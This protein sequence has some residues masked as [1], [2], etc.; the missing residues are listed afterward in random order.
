SLKSLRVKRK[1]RRRLPAKI[2]E[3]R[4]D[5]RHWGFLRQRSATF[6]ANAKAGARVPVSKELS[7]A[8]IRLCVLSLGHY[9]CN[10]CQSHTVHP[11][12]QCAGEPTHSAFA[13]CLALCAELA[14]DHWWAR[15]HRDRLALAAPRLSPL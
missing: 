5:D 6:P 4:E 12:H 9:H 3:S 2:N 15:P 14:T 11:G 8:D 7:Y 1:N 13:N 10:C